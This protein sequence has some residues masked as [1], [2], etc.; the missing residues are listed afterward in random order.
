MTFDSNACRRRCW[1]PAMIG[2]FYFAAVFFLVF[3]GLG[4]KSLSGSED[5]WAEIAR[6]MLLHHDWFHPTINGEI[7]FDKPLLSL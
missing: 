6:N 5:R 3:F 4:Q 7:Y 1:P 2:L